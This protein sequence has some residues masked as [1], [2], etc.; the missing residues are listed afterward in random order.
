[1]VDWNKQALAEAI[2]KACEADLKVKLSIGEKRDLL[3]DQTTW[4]Y[5]EIKEIVKSLE[6]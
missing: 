5:E 6:K 1:M 2:I 3:M 4:S